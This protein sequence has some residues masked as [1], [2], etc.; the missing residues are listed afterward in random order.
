MN[1]AHQA[2]MLNLK[3]KV[4]KLL[5]R[6]NVLDEIIEEVMKINTKDIDRKRHDALQTYMETYGD[7]IIDAVDSFSIKDMA[8]MAESLI[9]ITELQRH[10]SS[11]EDT[12]GGPIDV[13]VVTK[14]EGFRWLKCK[15]L[16]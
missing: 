16:L 15:N 9:S 2:A 8:N 14:A 6:E 4:A 12:V 11:S 7:S 1:V 13:A 10:F 3:E 5:K